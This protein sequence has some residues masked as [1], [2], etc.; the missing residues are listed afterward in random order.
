MIKFQQGFS[1]S[2]LPTGEVDGRYNVKLYSHLSIGG[3][4][5][6]RDLILGCFLDL[7]PDWAEKIPPDQFAVLAAEAASRLITSTYP[8]EAVGTFREDVARAVEEAVKPTLD[9]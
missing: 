4:A 7:D 3:S 8:P 5:T 9:H 6:T 2:F 1:M